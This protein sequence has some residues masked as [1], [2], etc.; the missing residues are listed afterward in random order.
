MRDRRTHLPQNSHFK[1][2]SAAGPASL[3]T[4]NH[5]LQFNKVHFWGERLF[6]QIQS[7]QLPQE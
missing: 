2:A 5:C 4:Q 6:W 7:L 3:S 1:R